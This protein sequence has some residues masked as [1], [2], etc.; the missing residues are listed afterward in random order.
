MKNLRIF[1]GAWEPAMKGASN[2]A[3]PDIESPVGV[4]DDAQ[5][6]MADGLLLAASQ[7]GIKLT[8]ALH[9]RYSLG[10]WRK[11][12]HAVKYSIPEAPH[13]KCK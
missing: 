13:L 5:L 9:N 3:V 10:C 7:R 6:D 2:P 1:L 8:V 12:A 4:W 11:D